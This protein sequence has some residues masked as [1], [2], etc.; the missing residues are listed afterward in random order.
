M[1]LSILICLA[2]DLGILKNNIFLYQSRSG[3]KKSEAFLWLNTDRFIFYSTAASLWSIWSWNQRAHRIM[4]LFLFSS[5]HQFY[6]SSCNHLLALLFHFWFTVFSAS[7]SA[8]R[9]CPSPCY[10]II[11]IKNSYIKFEIYSLKHMIKINK[12][13]G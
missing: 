9:H 11:L 6:L 7:I 3:L 2:I 5:F 8:E 13:K 12:Q 10:I 1:I 4:R